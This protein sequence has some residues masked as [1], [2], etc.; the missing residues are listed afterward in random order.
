MKHFGCFGLATISHGRLR[1]GYTAAMRV[2]I[3]ML[4]GVNLG[5]HKR[6][7]VEIK[8]VS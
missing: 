3:S 8:D 4:R 6:V 5:P 7:K 1:R 2:V